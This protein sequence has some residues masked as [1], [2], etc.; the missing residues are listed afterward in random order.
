MVGH[1]YTRTA[2]EQEL[3][4]AEHKVSKHP[5]D[6]NLQHLENPPRVIRQLPGGKGCVYVG[7][8]LCY[9]PSPLIDGGLDRHFFSISR[10]PASHPVEVGRIHWKMAAT[11][12]WSI[13]RATARD[14]SHAGGA[15]DSDS[16]GNEWM[17]TMP[18]VDEAALTFVEFVLRHRRETRA[19]IGALALSLALAR[20]FIVHEMRTFFF[21][22][23]LQVVPKFVQN[24]YGVKKEKSKDEG[25]LAKE[26]KK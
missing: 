25:V 12:P 20:T 14:R 6:S 3:K 18:G 24:N 2:S 26:N 16:L 22:F 10:V 15:G 19:I 4:M 21:V 1:A 8:R 17:T 13:A 11:V 5:I 23:S 9:Q 7:G